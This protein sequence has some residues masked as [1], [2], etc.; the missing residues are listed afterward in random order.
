MGTHGGYLYK[1]VHNKRPEADSSST[2]ER[3]ISKIFPLV[4]LRTKV[5]SGYV[6]MIV[7]LMIGQPFSQNL[8]KDLRK[9]QWAKPV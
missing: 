2:E 3:F 5:C 6:K 7:F 8:W 1:A 9:Q 4:K